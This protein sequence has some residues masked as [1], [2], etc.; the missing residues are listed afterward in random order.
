MGASVFSN[1][2]SGVFP[3]THC[4]AGDTLCNQNKYKEKQMLKVKDSKWLISGLILTGILGLGT[5]VIAADNLPSRTKSDGVVSETPLTAGNYCHLKF[6]AV[7][8]ST[9]G[10]EHP[11]LKRPGTGDVID[12]YGPCNHDP[13]GKDEVL[14]QQQEDQIF[15]DR[16]H[17]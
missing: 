9:L 11:Q 6:P 17:S 10:T 5:Q 15:R 7:R 4:G 16:Y 14:S 13:L 12:F 1:G 3:F 2:G 8:P